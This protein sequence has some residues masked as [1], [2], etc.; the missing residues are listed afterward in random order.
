M[1]KNFNFT[2]KINQI[3]KLKDN[4]DVDENKYYCKK[5]KNNYELN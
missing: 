4:I 2:N 5:L 3:S 1:I